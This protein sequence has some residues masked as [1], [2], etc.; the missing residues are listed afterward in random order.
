AVASVSGSIN[1]NSSLFRNNTTTGASSAG[2]AVFSGSGA[3]QI[4][5]STFIQNSTAGVSSAGGAVAVGTAGLTI[6]DSLFNEN[7]TQNTNSPGGAVSTGSGSV[8]T[9]ASRFKGNSTTAADSSG[10]AI[11]SQ[12]GALLL[13]STWLSENQTQADGSPGSAVATASASVSL[14]RSTF[15][16][17][18]SAGT[19]SGGAIATLSGIIIASQST[20]SGN[21]TLG[22]GS[23]G[24]AIHAEGGQVTISQSTLTRNTAGRNAQAA[25]SGGAIFTTNTSV[26]IENSII[27]DNQAPATG[28]DISFTVAT[29]KT[30]TVKSSLIGRS[31]GTALVP[32]TGTTPDNLGNLIGGATAATA[33]NPQLS[34]LL[35]F[36]GPVPVHLPQANSP[37]VDR[38][39]NA[40][41][42]DR[43][44]ANELLTTDQR[45]NSLMKRVVGGTVDMGATERFSLTAPLVVTIAMDEVDGNTSA[46]DLSLREAIILANGSAGT[47]TITFAPAINGS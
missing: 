23:T 27:A 25:I 34:A 43:T 21:A 18:F 19:F 14:R 29:G 20:F 2:G 38:G 1:I 41:A 4:S 28:T 44:K 6:T 5:G 16:D 8:V 39:S 40:L 30:L 10:G 31:D 45:Q 12:S 36:G 46:T 7:S 11:F 42:V 15:A 17:N 33:I 26:I 35:Q 3:V 47:D 32:T 13:D 24:A 37:A 22:T 9:T